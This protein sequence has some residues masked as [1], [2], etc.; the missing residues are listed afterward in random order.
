MAKCKQESNIKAVFRHYKDKTLFKS[1]QILKQAE[2]CD[3]LMIGF[4]LE[5]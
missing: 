5:G 3:N 2:S 4:D 1:L